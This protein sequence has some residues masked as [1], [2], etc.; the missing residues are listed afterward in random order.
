MG[1]AELAQGAGAEDETDDHD[2]GKEDDRNKQDP[3]HA[4]APLRSAPARR[5]LSQPMPSLRSVM[6]SP[7]FARHPHDAY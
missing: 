5:V 7:R 3:G 2:G 1:D 4:S 6:R